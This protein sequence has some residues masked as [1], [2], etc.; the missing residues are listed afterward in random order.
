MSST[1]GLRGCRVVTTSLTARLLL[2]H[3][4]RALSDIDWTVVSGDPYPDAPPELT[5]EVI[6]LRRELAPA[7]VR[8]LARLTSYLRRRRFDLVQT[9][10]PKAS[11]LGLPAARLSGSRAVYTIHG[12]LYFRGN[13]RLAN[14][15]GWLFER[16]C[17]TWAHR[18]LVQSRE[19]ELSLPR[20]RI[21]PAHKVTYIGN[22]I[23]LSRFLE[24]VAPALSSPRPIVVMISRLVREKGCWD[25]LAVAEALAGRADFVH[26]GPF[27]DDQRD[28]LSRQDIDAATRA[29][30]M[31]FVGAVDDVRP[32]LSAADLVVLPSYREGIPRAAMEAAATGTPVVAYDVRG[33]RE[34]IDPDSGLLAPRGDVAG[35]TAIVARLLDDA[36][37][38]RALGARCR[39]RVVD[40]FSE[41]DVV[42]RLRRFYDA[43]VEAVPVRSGP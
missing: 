36:P 14:A 43:L 4:L 11:V 26:V 20:A 3:Q 16:W 12:A 21:C 23:A 41:D 9:H 31:H 5:V 42:E 7:D 2:R 8:S 15:L 22:G 29:G 40:R 25:Y 33:V 28:A 10:T 39:Q 13:G 34:V 37:G 32:Y 35:L 27:E 18:V 38:R 24:P 30:T 6:P 19:D 17:C 1:V